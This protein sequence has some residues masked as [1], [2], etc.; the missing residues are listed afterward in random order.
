MDNQLGV[1]NKKYAVLSTY[2]SFIIIF[3]NPIQ[4][5]LIRQH[6]YLFLLFSK[7]QYKICL[8][9]NKI[10]H[11]TKILNLNCKLLVKQKEDVLDVIKRQLM[12]KLLYNKMI[13]ELLVLLKLMIHGLNM[14]KIIL[15]LLFSFALA[16]ILKKTALLKNLNKYKMMNKNPLLK[17]K[18]KRILNKKLK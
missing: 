15:T 7:T 17:K 9:I 8:F 14:N 2:L 11:W 13:R 3:Q 12:N 18:K 16:A 1:C 6:I 5:W 10:I 4:N